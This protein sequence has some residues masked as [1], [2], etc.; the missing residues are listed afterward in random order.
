MR[1]LRQPGR[2]S[3]KYSGVLN[4]LVLLST[5]RFDRLVEQEAIDGAAAYRPADF[6]ADVRKGIWREIEGGPVR[7]DAYRRNLQN[8][9]IDL[10]ALKLNGRPAVTD[11]YRALIRIELRDLSAAIGAAQPRA[12]DRQTRA[13]LADARD[14]IAKA[15]DPRFAPPA[16]VTTTGFPLGFEQEPNSNPNSVENF[17]PRDCWPDY[18]IKIRPRQ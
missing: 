2:S 18:A 4:R 14:Q 3:P 10:L 12:L 15:L 13:H 16:S 7:I 6:L 5:A 9:Y 17:D 1:L 8:S 11:D